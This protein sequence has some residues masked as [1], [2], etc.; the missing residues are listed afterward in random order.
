MSKTVKGVF[1]PQTAA[2][3]LE[4]QKLAI[5]LGFAWRRAGAKPI[6]IGEGQSIR[7]QDGNRMTP[8]SSP[9]AGEAVTIDELKAAVADAQKGE[10]VVTRTQLLDV[11]NTTK[12]REVE[13]EIKTILTDNFA[14]DANEPIVIAQA[15]VDRAAAELD[16]EQR[17]YFADA[18]IVFTHPNDKYTVTQAV[19]VDTPSNLRGVAVT[20]L[21]VSAKLGTVLMDGDGNVYF[22]TVA[23]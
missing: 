8:V 3:S 1:T 11:Y 6:S 18:G 2:E 16:E 21:G 20:E 14:K 19:G 9:K 7:L 4:F 5:A 23:G 17:A 10:F 15:L 12:C 13:A 22:A